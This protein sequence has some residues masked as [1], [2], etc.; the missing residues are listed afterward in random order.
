MVPAKRRLWIRKRMAMTLPQAVNRATIT[1]RLMPGLPVPMSSPTTG[2]LSLYRRLVSYL[3]PT[4]HYFAVSIL[5]FIVYAATQPWLASIMKDIEETLNGGPNVNYL[6]VPLL[7][8]GIVLVRGTGEFVGNFFMALVARGLVHR[9]RTQSFDSMLLLPTRFFEDSSSG[10]L[11]YKVTA[12]VENVTAAV[13]RALTIIIREGATSIA[14][15]GYML[16]SNWKLT[17]IFLATAPLIALVVRWT[18]IRMR[19]LSKQMQQSRGVITH[20]AAESI[21][22]YKEIKAFEAQASES[23]RFRDASLKNMQQEVKRSLTSEAATPIVQF[24]YAVALS[25]LLGIAL[26]PSMNNG[27]MGELMAYVAAAALMPKS[28]R[29]LTT[30]NSVIQQGLAAAE[31]IFALLD[32]KP[33]HDPGQRELASTRGDIVIQ[34]LSFQ[35]PG[36]DKQ[37][38]N[39]I[40]LHI[41]AGKTV[42]IVGRSGSGKT[43]LAK[44]VARFYDYQQG[45]ILIDGTDV[46]E[47]TLKSY[48]RQISIV[49]QQVTLFNGTIGENIAFGLYQDASHDDIMRAAKDAY[50]SEFL[51]QQPKGLDTLV[52]E[53]GVNLSGGQRQRVAIARALLKNAPILILDEATSA[54]D[55]ESESM[56]QAALEKVMRHR[57]TIVIAH[58]LSTIENADVIV[59]MDEGR[60]IE[61]GSHQQLLANGGHYARLHS[62]QF[63]DNDGIT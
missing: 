49:S 52:G 1:P 62:R 8:L 42:A 2:S 55:N 14:L 47:F 7:A 50:V 9:L 53:D 38:L 54:L 16:W 61:S 37:V 39:N 32:E 44:L 21:N 18:S 41:P 43:T 26:Y 60:I 23:Q 28:L 48:R 57:T 58:R 25:I 12:L 45:E 40:S 24:I 13:T 4:W 11:I 30:V 22:G 36:Q 15:L 46:R 31:D 20:I 10:Q 35:Y 56:I 63:S 33:E 6:Y 27:S 34:D 3:K 51:D 59:V 5:G 17:L 29:Q 19:K